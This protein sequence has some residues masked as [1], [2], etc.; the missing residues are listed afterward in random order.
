[1]L[2]AAL[3]EGWREDSEKTL[4]ERVLI[5]TLLKERNIEV[6]DDEIEAEYVRLSERMDITLDELKKYYSN[7]REK[8]YLI[9]D[10]KEKKLYVQLFE[11]STV[12][13]G[14]KMTVEQ[15]LGEGA[16]DVGTDA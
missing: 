8:E 10:I 5:E 6:S 11:K 3:L 4:K 13:P 14:E 2:K 1:M 9:D 15:L 16:A 7:P 12:T